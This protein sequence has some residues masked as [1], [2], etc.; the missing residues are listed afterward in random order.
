ME[1]LSLKEKILRISFKSILETSKPSASK[2]F[3]IHQ[4]RLLLK[5]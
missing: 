4:P 3:K 5:Y 1:C 2:Y